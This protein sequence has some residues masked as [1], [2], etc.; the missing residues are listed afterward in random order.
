[1]LAVPWSPRDGFGIGALR[2]GLV[3]PM[4]LLPRHICRCKI[5][6]SVERARGLAPRRCGVEWGGG[7][8]GRRVWE[9]AVVEHFGGGD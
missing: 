2:V 8:D 5:W 3:A 4:K 1:M 9:N 7:V 6:I